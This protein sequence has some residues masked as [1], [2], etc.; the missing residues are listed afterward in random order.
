MT[1]PPQP[2]ASAPVEPLPSCYGKGCSALPGEVDG[3]QDGCRNKPSGPT[4]TI[5]HVRLWHEN[6]VTVTFDDPG[7]A[8]DTEL[9]ERALRMLDSGAITWETTGTTDVWR[10]EVAAPF[11]ADN[12]QERP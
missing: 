11:L 8:T 1:T 10:V 12:A 3:H 2:V 7:D 4:R 6:E 9:A 5:A